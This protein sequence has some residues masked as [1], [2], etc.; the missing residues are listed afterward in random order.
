LETLEPALGPV[1]R[2]GPLGCMQGASRIESNDGG[3]EGG[4]VKR[5]RGVFAGKVQDKTP[6]PPWGVILNMGP[7]KG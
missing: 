6:P 5:G 7:P 2:S 4:G 3:G 1:G